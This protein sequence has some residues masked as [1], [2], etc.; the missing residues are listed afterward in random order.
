MGDVMRFRA[1]PV[2]GLESVDESERVIRGVSC[3]QAVEALGH[4]FDLDRVTLEQIAELGNGKRGVK[5]RFTHPGLSDDGLG[6]YLGRLRSFR[7]VDDKVLAD[8]HLSKLAFKSPEG[9]LGGYILERARDEPDTFGMSVVIDGELV[10][11]REDGDEVPARDGRPPDAVGERPVVRV[12]K[13]VACDAVDEPAANRDGMFSSALWAS[14]RD[15]EQAYAELDGLLSRYGVSR[16]KALQFAIK[17]FNSRGVDPKEMKTMSEQVKVEQVDEGAVAPDVVGEAAP[18][19][20]QGRRWAAFLARKALDVALGSS[21]LPAAAVAAARRNLEALGDGLTPEAIEA[22]IDAQRELLASLAEEQ[23]IQGV[24]PITAG[25][26]SEPGERLQDALSW[27]FGD[28]E[29]GTP[30][31]SYRNIRDIYLAITGDINFRGVFDPNHAML[32]AATTSTLAGMAVNA[33]NKV[34]LQHYEAM[35]TYRW[36]EQVVAVLPHDGSTHDVQMVMMDGVANL[37][38]VAEG[39]A[40]TELSVGDSKETMAFGKRGNYVGI[41]LE[42]FRRSEIGK[43][44]AIPRAMMMSSVRTRSAAVANF[45]TSNGGVGPT[46]SDSVALFDAGHNNLATTAFDAGGTAWAAA[47][48]E[49]Y[50]NNVPGTSSPLGLWPRYALVPI[51]LYD[52]ALTLFGYGDGDVGKPTGAGTAQEV[53]P[54]AN[55]RP[56]DPRPVPIAVPEFT[57][58]NDWA[59]L[60]DPRLHPVLCMSYANAPQGGRHALPEIFS[61]TGDDKGLVFTNDVLPVKIRDWFAVGVATYVGIGKRNVA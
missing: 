55:D 7:V 8:L 42:M 36:F 10:W 33:L 2:Y 27:A 59:Y 18:E 56:G 54:Y 19:N 16:E 35:A 25:D 29:V 58:A 45:F 60:V 43:I 40:Y 11:L 17:Y 47:R 52:T 26:M 24:K 57:D 34:I 20:E 39:D 1:L 44:Q 28:R 32:A 13:L 23:V 4:G 12:S 50:S 31:P 53:N 21:G 6:K 49:C 51:D 15:A 30:A 14:N 22:E 61:V 37:S 41:T 38:T 46:L 48:K 9:N 3:A 5:C